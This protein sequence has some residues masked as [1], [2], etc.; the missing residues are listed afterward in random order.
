MSNII[1]HERK[2]T[3]EVDRKQTR[4]E[5]N[6]RTLSINFQCLNYKCTFLKLITEFSSL[7]AAFSIMHLV[8]RPCEIN[9]Q[10]SQ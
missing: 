3:K 5:I 9:G 10:F 4:K 8:L 7:P 6:C 2:R 1:K